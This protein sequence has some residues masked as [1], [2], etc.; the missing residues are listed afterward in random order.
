MLVQE[1]NSKY[2]HMEPSTNE[3][4]NV[5]T[6]IALERK[7]LELK[8]SLL[9]E[10]QDTTCDCCIQN[11][12]WTYFLRCSNVEQDTMRICTDRAADSDF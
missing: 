11:N 4:A 7:R 5:L 1:V 12:N 3:V 8:H 2:F 9:L 10:I 6:V